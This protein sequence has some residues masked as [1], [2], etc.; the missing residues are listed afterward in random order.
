MYPD[1]VDLREYYESEG[2][3][4]TRRLVREACRRL[5]PNIAGYSV[6]GLGY[7]TPYL[8][9]FMGEA[10]RL[11]AFMPAP[12][13][14]TW[15][16]R[17]AANATALVEETALPLPDQSVNR[18][19]LIH[20]LENTDHIANL[21]HEASRVLDAQGRMIVAV[22]GSMG[23]WARERF[24]PFSYG[25]SFSLAHLR[26][27]LTHNNFQ[28]EH[29]ERALFIPPFA[30]RWSPSTIDW[31]ERQ[32]RRC[33]PSFAGLMLVEVSKQV[34]SRPMREKVRVAPARLAPLLPEL[35]PTPPTAATR[36]RHA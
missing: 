34:Y 24:S 12:Q 8:R 32:G 36:G 1:V 9:P 4:L 27:V 5:W 31:I 10:E 18:I 26:R 7:A 21:L 16:P 13:G 30:R 19:L 20:A 11:M 35:I 28:I 22:P 6:L 14:V 25:F 2:G 33:I 23:W 17:D 3:Q 15:W 29:H